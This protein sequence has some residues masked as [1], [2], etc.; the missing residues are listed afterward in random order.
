MDED[1]KEVEYVES[2]WP[3]FGVAHHWKNAK[4]HKT[5]TTEKGTVIEMIERPR[6]GMACYMNG[7][8]QS[9]LAD[10]KIYHEALVHPAMVSVVNPKRVLIIGGGEGATAREVLKWRSVERVDMYEWDKDVVE[11]FRGSYPEWGKGVW[12]DSRLCIHYKDFFEEMNH[13]PEE[14]YD[15]IIVDLFEPSYREDVEEK[16]NMWVLYHKLSLEWL[17]R[18]G[19]IT[20]YSGIRNHFN[21]IH[22]SSYLYSTIIAKNLLDSSYLMN[23]LRSLLSHKDIRSYKVF[24]PSYSGEAM[25]ILLKDM[26][27]IPEWNRLEYLFMGKVEHVINRSD[28]NLIISS[29]LSEEVWKGYCVWNRY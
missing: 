14:R 20:M 5:I 15:V 10:E 8:I 27:I 17:Q 7:E 6:W 21:D 26:N 23:N 18:D 24:I 13:Y 2:T 16:N 29:H 4:I 12:D 11:L 3:E 1:K 19:A 25:F 22:P 28:D 9:C